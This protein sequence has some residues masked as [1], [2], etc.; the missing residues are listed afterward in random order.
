[1]GGN[2]G[3]KSLASTLQR[4]LN[5]A[6]RKQADALEKLSSGQVFTRHDPRPAD[7]ALAEGLEF[8]IRSLSS[9][10]RNINDAV[11]LLQI[12]ES[13]MQE[14]TN[15]VIRMKEINV[16]AANTTINDKERRYLF[17]EYQALHDEVNR[18]AMSTEYNGLPLLNGRAANAPQ[19]LVFR[20]GDVSSNNSSRRGEDVNV[21]KFDGLRS[22]VATTDALG[23]KSAREMLAETNEITGITLR[24]ARD[25]LAPETDDFATT[26][27]QAL[28]NLATQR[29]V[30]GALQSRLNR[31]M[32]WV[33]VYQE[34]IT[35]AKSHIADVDYASEMTK[36]ASGK[37]LAQAASALIGHTNVAATVTAT[38]LD[39]LNN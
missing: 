37:I 8:K 23:L 16:A 6:Q 31:A 4:H 19:E 5:Q 11:S 26:Y 9:A 32:D 12:G 28:S 22:I 25:M 7:R 20:V 14:I 2:I 33:D 34:N 17:V 3:D 15:M 27:D 18:V 13:G 29:S 30:F 24:D 35:A 10:K 1:M 39:H 21:I 38:L 36:L